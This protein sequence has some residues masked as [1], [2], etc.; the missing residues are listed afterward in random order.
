MAPL[1]SLRFG[2]CEAM[3]PSSCVSTS[4]MMPLNSCGKEYASESGAWASTEATAGVMKSDSTRMRSC[5]TDSQPPER[6]T[7]VV[8]RQSTRI[9][10]A[11][12]AVEAVAVV[13]YS[14]TSER[15]AVV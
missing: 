4:W 1:A 7:T 11:L 13:A 3:R 6:D 9:C 15:M 10:F 5:S 8:A 14:T 2:F 12:A